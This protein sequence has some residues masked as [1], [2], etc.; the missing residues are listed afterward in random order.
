MK[1]RTRAIGFVAMLMLCSMLLVTSGCK[2]DG[3]TAVKADTV[4]LCADCGQIKGSDACCVADAETCTMCSLAKDAPGCCVME[5]G[6]ADVALCTHCGQIAGS[7]V[8]CK[9]DQAKCEKCQLAEGSPGCCKLPT[10]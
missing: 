10:E 1:T 9:P 7:D 8:C 5:K 3:T 2:E 4:A 6:D